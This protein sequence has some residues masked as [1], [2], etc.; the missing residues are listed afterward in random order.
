MILIIGYGNT[1]RSDDGA[2][3][4][5]AEKIDNL[6]WE[7]VRTI[8]VHQL[9]PELAFHIAESEKVIFIDAYSCTENEAKLK[10]ES[11]NLEEN[12]VIL[13]HSINPT[14]LLNLSH[15]LYNKLPPAWWVL[16]PA[17]SF[18]FGENISAITNQNI[19]QAITCIKD[20]IE[21]S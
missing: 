9:T 13:P 18:D 21:T 1:L 4:L 17:I 10:I 15:K 5:V 11:L 6:E 7:N 3:Q 14:S 20:L 16:I 19:E 2:G 8:T 12:Q